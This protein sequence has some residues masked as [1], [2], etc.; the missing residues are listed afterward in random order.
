MNIFE[1][2]FMEIREMK[3]VHKFENLD[4]ESINFNPNGFELN[5]RLDDVN[6]RLHTSLEA[7]LW[8]S[9]AERIAEHL[10]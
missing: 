1:N 3:N 5:A 8:I 9:I 6:L 10:G 2:R 4:Y 7:S